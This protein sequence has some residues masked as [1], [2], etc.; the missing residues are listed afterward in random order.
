MIR[1]Y[2]LVERVRGYDPD[3]SEAALNR[4]YVFSMSRHGSQKRAS[5]DPYFS[6]P[7]EVAG[8]LTDLKLDG[9]SIITA[10]LHDTVEDGVASEGEIEQM[11]GDEI[12]RLVDGVTK[13]GKIELQSHTERQAENFRK[14]L[15]AMSED[16]RVLLVKLADRLHNM[17]TLHFIDKPEK[18]LR[19]AVETMDIYV[20]LAERIG[21]QRMKDELEDLA[22]REIN[23]EAHD[24]L[25][26]RLDFLRETEGEM[27]GLIAS[28]LEST[29]A[30]VGIEAEVDGREKRPYSIWLKMQRKHVPFEQ[31]ADVF[32]FRVALDSLD[33]CYRALGAVHRTYSMIPG[34]FKDYISTPKQNGYQSIH[35]AVIGPHKQRVE[36]QLRTVEMHEIAEY[37]VAAHWIYKHG[38]EGSSQREGRQYRWIRHLLEILDHAGGAE[39]FLEHT[40]LEMF[41]DQVFCFS[42]KGD[43]ISLPAGA[44]PVDFAYAVHSDI[45]DTCVGA[46]INGR[47]GPL[48]TVLHNGDQVEVLRSSVPAPDPNWENFVVTG[49]ARAR[50]RR[51]VRQRANDEY[52]SL[53]RSILEKTFGAHER[54]FA[55]HMLQP[56]LAKFNVKKPLDLMVRVGRG[57]V[58][59]E[60]ALNAVYPDLGGGGKV[61]SL[62]RIA[63]SD[64]KKRG[65]AVPIRGLT[66]GMAVHMAE[67]CYPL[68]GD[69]IVGLVTEGRGVT[70]HTI[71][72]E[73]LESFSN[74]PERWLDVSWTTEGDDSYAHTGRMVT[75]I[76]NVPG[77]LNALTEAIAQTGGNITNLRISRRAPD[78]FELVVDVEVDDV[79]HLSS[80]MAALRANPAIYQVERAHG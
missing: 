80:I 52:A 16:I 7:V 42:P 33:D 76:N 58:N 44:T 73:V 6:H 79:R 30:G 47:M 15:L 3:A 9:A 46:K 71:D 63:G 48:R 56:V 53:G 77:S 61:V 20:P 54:P 31:V 62:P 39:E 27:I 75:V 2:E 32:A 55:D 12:G 67:C 22:F 36:V 11:F 70:I 24:S 25:T 37:G 23:P 26:R 57:E 28:E 69:R 34:R 68:P 60:A 35:T 45:G 66:P 43:L 49:K 19:I 1:Q 4:A 64:E 72:C 38:S 50:I 78:F 5:G 74:T 8:I 21:M 29:L 14:F 17:R 65:G 51:F 13:L 18:R 40:K 41:R 10:L 59:A